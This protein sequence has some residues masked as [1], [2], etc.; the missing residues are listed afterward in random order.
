MNI[1]KYRS[2]NNKEIKK[3]HFVTRSDVTHESFKKKKPS[4]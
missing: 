1:G 2:K 4:I 3:G